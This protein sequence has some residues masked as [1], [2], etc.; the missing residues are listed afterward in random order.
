[1]WLGSLAAGYL[2]EHF[3][4][5]ATKAVD[6]QSFWLVPSAGVMLSRFVFVTLFR[7][8]PRQPQAPSASDPDKL[9]A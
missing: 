7:M 2:K 5:P 1:M 3:T 4:D 8:H 9:V 6:W